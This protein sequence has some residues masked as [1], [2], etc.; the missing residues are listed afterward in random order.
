MKTTSIVSRSVWSLIFFF[1][2]TFLLSGSMSATTLF[3][4]TASGELVRFDSAT[5]GTVVSVGAITGLQG[6]ETVVG[7]DFRPATGQLY[8]LGSTGR[9][10]ILNRTNASATLVATLSTALNGTAFGVDF[11]PVVDR[12]RVVSDAGKNLRINPNDGATIVDGAINGPT[13]SVVGGRAKSFRRLCSGVETR[14]SAGQRSRYS[15]EPQGCVQLAL[16]AV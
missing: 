12:L 10:Y 11:N 14:Q 6:G 13:T 3:S 15:A 9:L 5:P 7:I 16:A 4:V 1:S 2:F 8:A